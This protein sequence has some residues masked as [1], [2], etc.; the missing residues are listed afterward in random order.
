MLK[1]IALVVP[2]GLDSFAICAALSVAGLDRRQR[3][4]VAILFPT[5]EAAAP[6]LGLAIGAPLGTAI[7]E[8]ADYIAAALLIAFG[9]FT[10]VRGEAAEAERA[11]RL[12]S[13]TGFAVIGLGLAVA[14][15]ELAIG[16]TIGLLGL[17]LVPT[18]VLIAVQAIV[19]SQLGLR[20][21]AHLGERVR[22]DA[23]RVASLA[24]IA[25][26]I[27]LFAEKIL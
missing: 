9:L 18:L 2:L 23:E 6:L 27:L 15:D 17:P 3:L 24:L 21:G 20:F 25:V 8:V 19:F 22:E 12:T 16:F 1:V 14:L 11:S 4:R 10:L 13:A 7:G 26:G 5:F